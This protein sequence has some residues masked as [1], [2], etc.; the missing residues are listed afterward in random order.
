MASMSFRFISASSI[1]V[2]CVL[3][4]PIICQFASANTC[5]AVISGHEPSVNLFSIQSDLTKHQIKRAEDRLV[6]PLKQLEKGGKDWRPISPLLVEKIAE[7]QA[8]Y[9]HT[10]FDMMTPQRRQALTN[11]REAL[12]A[13]E[14]FS[15]M[16]SSDVDDVVSTIAHGNRGLQ[17][18]VQNTN[19]FLNAIRLEIGLVNSPDLKRI[20][21]ELQNTGERIGQLEERKYELDEAAADPMFSQIKADDDL[22]ALHLRIKSELDVAS[23]VPDDVINSLIAIAKE[24]Q[25][26]E[27]GFF[28][29]YTPGHAVADK[30]FVELLDTNPFFANATTEDRENLRWNYK[31]AADRDSAIQVLRLFVK[32]SNSETKQIELE[33]IERFYRA[34][35]MYIPDPVV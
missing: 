7:E 6:K 28:D 19:Q 14:E 25:A 34:L 30:K 15:G 35:Q 10:G 29:V 4:S 21:L 22:I 9:N 17:I 31:Q 1:G 8:R 18:P 26:A 20:L 27:V 3:I 13:S 23:G 2:L 24:Y 11:I 16:N 12:L 33:K 32:K 5:D